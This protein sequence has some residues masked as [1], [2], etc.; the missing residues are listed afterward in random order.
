MAFAYL[1]QKDP[2]ASNLTCSVHLSS[3]VF[4]IHVDKHVQNAKF[5]Y[6]IN[7]ENNRKNSE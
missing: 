6:F 2:N 5:D 4:R 7:E 3:Q 1:E